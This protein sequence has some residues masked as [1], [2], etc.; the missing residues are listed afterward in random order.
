MRYNE[1]EVYLTATEAHVVQASDLT[2]SSNFMFLQVH[3]E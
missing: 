2:G 3:S 1:K